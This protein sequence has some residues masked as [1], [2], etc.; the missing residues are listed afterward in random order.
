MWGFLL[1]I[2]R[3]WQIKN[4]IHLEMEVVFIHI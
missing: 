4:N 2:I 3:E 1:G